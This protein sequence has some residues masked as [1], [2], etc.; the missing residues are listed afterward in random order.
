M[1]PYCLTVDDGW[2]TTLCSSLYVFDMIIFIWFPAH[3]SSGCGWLVVAC[4]IFLVIPK[5]YF[6]QSMLKGGIV[7]VSLLAECFTKIKS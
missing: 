1:V 5:F 6:C 4:F 2:Y 7:G 3:V